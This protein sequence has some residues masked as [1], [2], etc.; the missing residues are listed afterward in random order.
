MDSRSVPF[1]DVIPS[2]KEGRIVS[3]LH[4]K[5]LSGNIL[6]HADSGHPSHVT[7][8]IPVGQFLR[9]RRVCSEE[10]DL[11]KLK[12]VMCDR[13]CLGGYN[14]DTLRRAIN[15]MRLSSRGFKTV[16]S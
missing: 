3:S 1:L 6:L 10:E 4:R 14:T 9:L 2:G 11:H 16:S 13:F 7:C 8:G 12:R 15:I 5:P